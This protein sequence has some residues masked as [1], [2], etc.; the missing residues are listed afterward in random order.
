MNN[1]MLGQVKMTE[2]QDF[3]YFLMTNWKSDQTNMN[4]ASTWTQTIWHDY[5][6]YVLKKYTTERERIEVVKGWKV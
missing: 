3:Q 5:V 2:I 6:K 4:C 1:M